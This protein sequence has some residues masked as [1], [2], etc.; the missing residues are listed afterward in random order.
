M[1]LID[2]DIAMSKLID[3]G[4]K[5]K[6]YKLGENWQLNYEE[7]KKAFNNVPTVDAILVEWIEK[8]IKELGDY[9]ESWN[10][11]NL[12]DKWRRENEIN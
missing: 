11:R 1:R 8:Q 5:T 3:E 9:E 7:V 6:R 12:I 10:Y 2:A 4:Q